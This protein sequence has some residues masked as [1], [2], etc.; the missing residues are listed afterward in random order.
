MLQL[1]LLL[2]L[3]PLSAF[4][5][6]MWVPPSKFFDANPRGYEYINRVFYA[7]GE[8]GY[9]SVRDTPGSNTEVGTIINGSTYRVSVAY[10][11]IGGKWGL[12]P[13]NGVYEPRDKMKTGWVPINQLVPV[14]DYISFEE[15]HGKEFYTYKG[16][17]EALF[18]ASELVFW[19]WPGSGE[20]AMAQAPNIENSPIERTWLAVEQAQ[21]YKDKEGREWVLIPY[22]YASKNRWICIS[23]PSNRD[24]PAFHPAP[25]PV[26]WP[27]AEQ[28]A[29]PD[30]KPQVPAILIVTIL[31]SVL[32]L[33]TVALI[34][35]LWGKKGD[36][37]I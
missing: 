37:P 36:V 12:I 11:S 1:L 21:A 27:A 35:V 10:D 8:A 22:F 16:D 15:E 25:A 9:V 7:N 26:L 31:V 29:I 17:Y 24:I 4:A 23:D 6:M 28:G 18:E 5:D 34:K 14:Y 2:L 32:V 19:N 3:I 33:V 13:L 20:I 30:N